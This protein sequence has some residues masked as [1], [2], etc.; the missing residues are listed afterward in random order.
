MQY[1]FQRVNRASHQK[2][3]EKKTKKKTTKKQKTHYPVCVTYPYSAATHTEKS[4]VLWKHN[5]RVQ[6]RQQT[7]MVAHQRSFLQVH[8]FYVLFPY[9]NF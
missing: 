4:Y 2:K 7:I 1:L 8:N 3:K 6:D 9:K 5:T